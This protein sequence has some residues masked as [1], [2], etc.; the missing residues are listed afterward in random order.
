MLLLPPNRS[1]TEPL[2]VVEAVIAL[3]DPV[4]P[5]RESNELRNGISKVEDFRLSGSRWE[6]DDDDDEKVEGGLWDEKCFQESQKGG[7]E[8]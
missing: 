8:G 7:D 6:D 4:G 3:E 1:K 2:E 5:R